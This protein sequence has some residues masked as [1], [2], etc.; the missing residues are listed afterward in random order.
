MSDSSMNGMIFYLSSLTSDFGFIPL[1]YENIDKTR[2][3]INPYGDIYS[4]QKNRIMKQDTNHAGYK[5]ICLLTED[6]EKRNFSIHRL[7]AYTFIFNPFPDIYT[8]VNH[9]DGNK[10]NNFYMNLEWCNNNQNKHYASEM[11]L[12]EHGEDRYNAVYTDD[13][14]REI[15]LKFQN[16]ISYENVYKYYQSLYPNTGNTIGSFVYKLY[17]RKT[18][19]HITKDY[20]Y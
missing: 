2:Y 9:I 8:D 6:G 10:S 19:N 16:G 1:I 7:V 20:K 5:R 4:I 12:Y 15:C 17:H 14:A 18:R 11:G 3:L 13:F